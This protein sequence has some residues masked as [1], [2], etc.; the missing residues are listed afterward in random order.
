[1]VCSVLIIRSCVFV[2][3]SFL[4]AD[5]KTNIFNST[6]G[7]VVQT[8]ENEHLSGVNDCAW[9]SD[10][11]LATGSD[12]QLVKIWDVEMVSKLPAV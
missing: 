6:T 8:L 11:L 10:T 9:I 7:E 5:K 2:Q 1:V 4:A 12:D 3:Q